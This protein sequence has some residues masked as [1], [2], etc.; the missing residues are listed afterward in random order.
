[1]SQKIFPKNFIW[2]AATASYQIEGAAYQD[3]RGLSVWDMF[4]RQP[5]KVFLGNTGD[6]ACDHYHRYLDDI[7]LMSDI[8]LQAYRLSISWPRVIPD[9][10]GKINEKGFDFYEKLID[11]LL[12]KNIQP[13]VTL[14]HWDYPYELYC[15]GGWLNRDCSDWFVSYSRVI[16]DRLSDRVSHWITLNEPQC[17][18]ELG[19]HLGN[20]APGL[21]LELSDLLLITH[22]TLLS[23]G[24][25]VQI[26]RS[27]AKKNPKIGASIVGVVSIPSTETS[28]N[29]EATKNKMFSISKKDFLNNTWFADPMIL[30]KY[31]DDGCELFKE[32]LPKIFNKDLEIINQPLDFFGT[33]I[34]HGDYVQA[35]SNG[36]FEAIP[37]LD[38]SP[39]TTMN[40]NITPEAFYW[41]PRFYYKRYQLPIIVTENGMANTDLLQ[42]DGKVHDPQ[43]ID[44]LTRY[45]REYHRAIEDGVVIDGYFL[46]SLLDNFE[47]EHGYKQRFGIIYVDYQSLKRTPKDSAYWYKEV[48]SSNGGILFK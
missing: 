16:V 5:G 30:G 2:G 45:L 13:W 44:F 26:I 35:K 47:W 18:I 3:G 40:W 8:G 23:H 43:R 29:I 25:A 14:F 36:Q 4:C 24:K 20:H 32:N 34:Y 42:I 48:I 27:H 1:M 31:P 12:E 15:K 33:N 46:W 41:G 38:G 6:I 28:E 11:S 9:G 17:F 10:I 37:M 19:H 21:K 7:K 39:L 22:N